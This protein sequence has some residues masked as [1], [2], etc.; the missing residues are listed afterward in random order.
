MFLY[1]LFGLYDVTKSLKYGGMHDG[2]FDYIQTTLFLDR[3]W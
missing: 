2:Y 1:I 3:F